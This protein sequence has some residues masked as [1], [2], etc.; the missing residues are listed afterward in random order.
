MAP[1]RIDDLKR[2]VLADPASI[3]FA[4]LAEEYRRAG[5]LQDAVSTCVAG[6][7]RHP[8][9]L[10]ARVTLGRAWLELG[11]LDAARRELAQ[12]VA[13][14]PDNLA[15]VK[16]LGEACRAAGATREASEWYAAALQLAPGD[17]DIAR[18]V[19]ELASTLAEEEE[20][21]E[22]GERRRALATIAAL[23]GWLEAVDAAR[24]RRRA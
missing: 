20:T 18:I 23:E 7:A 17:P 3:A 22:E 8:N 19:S 6:L 14:V 10:S 12:V 13:A 15:A 9:Y 24:A 1:S 16:S 4:Q 5:R 2:R 11:Q 21:V